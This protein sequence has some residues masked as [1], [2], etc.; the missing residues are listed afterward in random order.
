MSV[1]LLVV[2]GLESG[3]SVALAA[4]SPRVSDL[5]PHDDATA[6]ELLL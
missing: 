2:C 4:R 3:P 6:A 5:A 1:A